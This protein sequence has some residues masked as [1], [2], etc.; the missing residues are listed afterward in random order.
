MIVI[1]VDDP[2]FDENDTIEFLKGLG[3]ESA[4]IIREPID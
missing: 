1:E 4:Q 2:L 3:G